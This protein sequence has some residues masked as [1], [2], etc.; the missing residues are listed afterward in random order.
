MLHLGGTY[1][2]SKYVRLVYTIVNLLKHA[3]A[4]WIWN[5]FINSSLECVRKDIITNNRKPTHM[6]CIGFF[7]RLPIALY[8]S[9]WSKR[10]PS[11]RVDNKAWTNGGRFD[12]ISDNCVCVSDGALQLWGTH[13]CQH[14]DI[15]RHTLCVVVNRTWRSHKSLQPWWLCLLVGVFD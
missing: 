11:L 13:L 4:Q 9:S 6:M 14:S 2:W 15:F 12:C 5:N 3:F 1:A 7:L 8:I 10:M